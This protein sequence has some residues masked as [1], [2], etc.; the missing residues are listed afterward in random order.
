[1]T[2]ARDP[3]FIRSILP[4]V[5]PLF[6]HYH[7]L[8]VSGLERFPTGPALAVGN[9]NGGTMSPDMFGFMVAWWR[10]R[11][12]E[13]EAYG[14]AHDLVFGLPVL[15]K[16]LARLGAVHAH[17]GIARD[18]LARG[19]KVLVYPGGDLDAY[20]PSSRRHE[21]VFGRRTGFVRLALRTGVP[22]LPVVSLGA[23]EAFHVVT[24]GVA[25]ARRLGLKERFR[26]EA[27]PIA[28]GL[29]FGLVIGPMGYWPLPVRMKVR[30]LEPITWP[31]H[32]P[33]AANDDAI[34]GRCLEQV[35]GVMQTALDGMVAEGGFGRR[36]G[37]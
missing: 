16:M 27:L 6:E 18:L 35:R 2:G 1:V 24:D 33:A 7:Q 19:A 30:V 32:D 34:V 10:A 5:E 36:W 23:H 15:G 12:T 20:K 28:L 37:K 3:A 4:W 8:D 11:G 13:E 25:F 31:E 22:L 21:I 14:L 17:P 26:L 9:H 29:P